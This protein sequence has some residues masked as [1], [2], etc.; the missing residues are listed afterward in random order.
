MTSAIQIRKRLRAKLD[1]LQP[2]QKWWFGVT[3]NDAGTI[4]VPGQPGFI[5]VRDWAGVTHT[6]FNNV[7]PTDVECTVKVGEDMWNSRL[8]MVLGIANA[9]VQSTY[10]SV[11]PH[12][13]KHEWQG[14]DVVWVWGEQ[15]LTGLVRVLSGMTVSI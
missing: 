11:A 10:K 15:I 12:H 13:E 14:G 7:A 4:D 9:Y 1:T 8:P 3:G 2:K 5:Y 6:V